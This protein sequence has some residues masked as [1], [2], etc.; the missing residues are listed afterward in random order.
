MPDRSD[1]GRR[2][3]GRGGKIV[4]DHYAEVD[5]EGNLKIPAETARAMGLEPGARAKIR[6]FA[7]RLVL[8]RPVT[9]LARIYIEPTTLCNLQC[10]MCMRDTWSEPVGHMAPTTFHR[11][12]ESVQALPN[13]P[14]VFFCGYGEPLTH[15]EFL[16]MVR[17]VKGLGAPV[18]AITNGVLLDEE[19]AQALIEA[20][21]DMLWVSIDGAS[22]ECYADVRPQ[23]DLARVIQNLERLR[24]LR[25]RQ[26]AATPQVGIAFVA[27]RRNLADFSGVLRLEERVGARRFLVTNVYP[28]TPDLLRETLYARSLG[29]TLWSRSTIQLAR[30]DLDRDTAWILEPYLKGYHGPR[31]EGQEILWP[32]DAC[33]FVMRGSTCVRWD[34]QVS[35][36]LPLLHTHTSYLGD[37]RRTTAAYSVGSVL[38][39]RLP[40]LWAAPEYI[41]LR[42]RLED[43]DFPSCTSCNACDMAA[44]NQEDCFG[45]TPPRCGGCLWA[46][47]FIRCP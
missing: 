43:F 25:R 6:Q 15:P 27:M 39:R 16:D 17:R 1:G 28:H 5:A 8:H 33:P 38:D 18:E 35:P 46:Q 14:T 23:G 40:E 47:G 37:R 31:L 36:C 22:P 45:D 32:S 13:A 19:R 10:R 3:V 29:E 30:M 20:G 7:D 21:L 11:I 41:A 24:D 26:R 9:H 34:G 12:L 42:Q 44:D 4:K 2:T